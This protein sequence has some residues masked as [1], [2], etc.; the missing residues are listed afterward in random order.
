MPRPEDVV[1]RGEAQEV[2]QGRVGWS[3]ARD[4]VQLMMPLAREGMAF[5]ALVGAR[6]M[7]IVEEAEEEEEVVEESVSDGSMAASGAVGS[8]LR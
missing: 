4:V 1:G 2:V 6:R 5:A 3:M 8:P 7:G